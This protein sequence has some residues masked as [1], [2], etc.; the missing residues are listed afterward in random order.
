M[1]VIEIPGGY[2]VPSDSHIGKWQQECG[3]LDHDE[4][5]VPLACIYI[6]VGGTVIDCGAFDGDHTVAYSHK[7]GEHGLVIAIE[8]GEIAFKCL[9]HN[10]KFF[11]SSTLCVQVALSDSE[12]NTGHLLNPN[13]GASRCIGEGDIPTITLDCMLRD[14]TLNNVDFIK[15]DCEGWELKVL[16]G[17]EQTILKYLPVMLIEINTGALEEQ[18]A[19]VDDVFELILSWG[20]RVEI[21]QPEVQ[22]FRGRQ[23][24]QFDILCI[25]G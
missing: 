10:A 9:Q 19:T 8:P 17:A 22:E 14:R 15:I 4:F 25:H 3:K 2:L 11:P 18:K 21:I 7:V 6:P 20:Y 12:G 1:D 13:L 16:L 23:H 24:P 5:T